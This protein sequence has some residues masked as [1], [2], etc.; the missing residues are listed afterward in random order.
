MILISPKDSKALSN[1][2][3]VAKALNDSAFSK[4]KGVNINKRKNLIVVEVED[5]TMAIKELIECKMLG[6]IPVTC[7]DG[8]QQQ[9]PSERHGVI[10]PISPEI[11]LEEL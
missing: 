8:L 4:N 7:K 6:D 3:K 9:T 10:Y 2:V 5:S 1:P 11:E